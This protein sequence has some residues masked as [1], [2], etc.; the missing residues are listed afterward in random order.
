MS[1]LLPT[2]TRVLE[3]EA[4]SGEQAGVLPRLLRGATRA[5]ARSASTSTCATHGELPLDERRRRRRR[6]SPALIE[7]IEHAGLR[8]HGGAGFPTATKLRAVGPRAARPI[9]VVNAAEGEPASLE[10][11]DALPSSCRTSCS[12]A[13]SS[14]PRRSAPTR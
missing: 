6:E 7:L 2:T 5:A 1:N 11:Q 3:G 13:R 12:T 14:P 10:G 4:P 8:G 9:V